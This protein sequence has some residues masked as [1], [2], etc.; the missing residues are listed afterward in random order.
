MC[1]NE[2]VYSITDNGIGIDIKYYDSVFELFKRM[3]NVAGFDGS[4]VGLAIVKRIITLHNGRIWFQ[5]VLGKGT[6][7]YIA[8]PKDLAALT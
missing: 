5:S 7:F 3:D 2:V 6:T 8:F 1:N 4:G